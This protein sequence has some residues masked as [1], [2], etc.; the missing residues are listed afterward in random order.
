MENITDKNT[1]TEATP[2]KTLEINGCKVVIRFSEIEKTDKLRDI[3]KTL[4][5]CY[6]A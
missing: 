1:K 2:V 3:E 5:S 4:L 6:T